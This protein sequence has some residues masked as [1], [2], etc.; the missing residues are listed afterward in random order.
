MRAVVCSDFGSS[1]VVTV[2]RPTPGPDEVV[3]EVRRV[4]LSVTECQLYRGKRVAHYETVARRL[5]AGDAKLFGHEFCAEVVE[6]GS[7]VERLSVGDRVY[8][9]R[10]IPCGSCAYC[11]AGSERYC[12]EERGIG[13]DIP[14]ALAEAVALPAEPL[15]VVPD[16]VSD[17]ACAAL[18]PVASALLCVLEAGIEPG[19]AVAVVGTGVM[20]YACGQFALNLGAEVVFAADVADEKLRL[21]ADRGLIPVDAGRE[22][23]PAV[24]REHTGGV[25]PDVVFE[26]VGGD[27]THGTDGEDPLAVSV[28][29]ARRG[30]RVVQVGHVV[31]DVTVTPRVFRLNNVDWIN[32]ARGAVRLGPNTDSGELAASM[33]ADGRVDVESYVT[34]EL[35]SLDGFERAVELGLDPDA[36][37]LGPAQIVLRS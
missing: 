1:Q 9:P 36:D 11:R 31:G 16:D 22:D 28:R 32:P 24:V 34:T 6:T 37:T 26:A 20:G 14:G 29:T 17:A 15:Q 5:E 3:V 8:A 2:E 12:A 13:Y 25:G 19:D 35:G 4:Q 21:A 7:D 18:Q 27:Q 10:K 30:G 23:I 33:V